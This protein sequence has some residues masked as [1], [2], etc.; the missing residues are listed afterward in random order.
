MQ[1]PE[2]V[3]PTTDRKGPTW[4]THSAYVHRFPNLVCAA[5]GILTPSGPAVLECDRLV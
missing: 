3:T 2:E 1:L 5:R 4:E